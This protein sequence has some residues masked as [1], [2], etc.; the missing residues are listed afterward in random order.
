MSNI[1]TT[2]VRVTFGQ[3][4]GR[5]DT[6]LSAEIDSREDGLNGGKTSF[7]PGETV[8]FLVHKG[9]NV[10]IDSVE[11]SAGTAS[12]GS[13]IEYA[14]EDD[15]IF[16]GA[17]TASLPMP[18]LGIVSVRWMGRALG[19]VTLG[20]DAQTLTASSAGVAVARV[21]YTVKATTGTLTSPASID[22]ETNF[23]IA[24]LITGSVS[25]A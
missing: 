19:D 10:T 25:A 17:S 2:T 18:S 8:Y 15:V 1:P 21:K 9:A 12:L 20:T 5:G 23:S 24:V 14:K 11:A 16:E 6:Y 4:V 22:G 3:T 7:A 13:E